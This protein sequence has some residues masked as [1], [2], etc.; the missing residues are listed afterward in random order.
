L[1]WDFFLCRA[2]ARVV[3]MTRQARKAPYSTAKVDEIE[4]SAM[5]AKKQDGLIER[6]LDQLGDAAHEFARVS[7]TRTRHLDQRIK[8]L[9]DRGATA[10]DRQLRVLD[11]ELQR[12]IR[13]ATKS[14]TTFEQ[15]VARIQVEMQ[16]RVV[17][18]QP[19]KKPAGPK[20]PAVKK[21]A[22][23]KAAAKKPVVKKPVVK[24][25][26]VKKPAIKKPA[27][28]KPAIKKSAKKPAAKRSAR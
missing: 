6:L 21:P 18:A 28:K 12:E 26:V 8:A 14:L 1:H 13:L 10:T 2:A 25:P 24:K 9:V 16:G 11:T 15:R 17:K 19:G 20:A 23:K 4:E 7:E 22:V 27:I 3:T 5:P